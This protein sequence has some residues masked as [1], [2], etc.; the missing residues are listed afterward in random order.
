MLHGY[1]HDEPSGRGEF[2]RGSDLGGKVLE[3]R[4]YLQDLLGAQIRV[5]V[6]PKNI[7][8][9]DGLRAIVQA[10]LHFGGT[11]GVRAGW[12]L[13]SYS[14]SRNWLKL[15]K[16]RRQSA[17]GLPWILDLGDH[18]E[19]PGNA[20]TPSADFRK[21]QAAFENAL[22]MGG[23][24]CAATHYWELGVHSKNVGDPPVGE[25]LR[26]L[27]DMARKHP[28]VVWRSVGDVICNNPAIL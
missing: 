17:I 7:M 23:T 6:A 19:I 22:R 21:N 18:R 9:R 1:Y 15:R 27:I 24:F 8:G 13:F 28:Q 4:K 3:G 10:G 2:S 5:F 16:W 25:H 11:V 20:I 14:T 26:R 12:P